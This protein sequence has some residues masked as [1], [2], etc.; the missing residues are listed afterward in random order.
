[1]SW[2]VSVADV[3]PRHRL[4]Y[5]T[6]QVCAAYV[7]LECELPDPGQPLEG[8]MVL[9]RL[10]S[11]ELSRVTA[12]AQTVR[13]TP[14]RIR[15][16]SED[17]FL[18]GI[19]TEGHAV[20]V[21]DG[22]EAQLGP[23]DFALF[24]STRPNAAHYL[25]DFQ[26]LLVKLPGTVMRAA[27]RDAHGLTARAVSG[28]RGAGQLLITMLSTL[29]READTLSPASV[30][31]VADS[32]THILVAGLSS[33]SEASPVPER[34]A[35]ELHRARIRATIRA[36]FRDPH[37]DLP[38][39]AAALRVSPSTLHRVLADERESLSD[40]LWGLRL[41]TAHRELSDPR[42][43]SRSVSEIAFGCGFRHAAHFSRAFRA[44]FGCAPSEL[45]P[46]PKR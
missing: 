38:A 45:R 19:Q 2:V 12:S 41:D 44:R 17:Y 34:S 33:L 9:H 23:G 3:E 26:Q 14:A 43:A 37:F 7:Q 4:A 32:V 39:L 40:L 30:A 8:E 20:I 24:D 18:V 31:A 6:E 15:R 11:L 28:T 46:R 35:A 29:A 10:A 22:R 1:M 42:L 13:R 16:D 21:Q 27:L 25:G 36:R 5:W